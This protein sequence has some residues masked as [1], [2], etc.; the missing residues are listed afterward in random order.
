MSALKKE[1]QQVDAELEGIEKLMGI[2]DPD[3]FYAEMEKHNAIHKATVTKKLEHSITTQ[4]TDQSD[5]V[6]QV[7]AFLYWRAVL[8]RHSHHCRRHRGFGHW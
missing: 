5:S 6:A 1:L 7:G 4:R 8:T 2:A 3:G